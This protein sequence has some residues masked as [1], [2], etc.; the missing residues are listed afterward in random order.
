MG[1]TS[2]RAKVTPETKEEARRLSELWATRAHPTQAEFGEQYGIGNQSA[3]GQFLRGDTPLSLKAAMG[4][5]EG[6]GVSLEDFSPRLAAEAAAI[7]NIVPGD[8]FTK[9]AAQVATAIDSLPPP[10]RKRVLILVRELLTLA[11]E[12][13]QGSGDAPKNE[14]NERGVKAA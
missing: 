4:F 11:R 13:A 6:L 14:T 3:V 5:A 10:E 1:N 7:A 2:R 9:E 12:S 8:K